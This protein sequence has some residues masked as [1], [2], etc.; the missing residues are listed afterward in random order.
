MERVITVRCGDS[1]HRLH[2]EPGQ[3]TPLDHTPGDRLYRYLGGS[4][5]GCYHW[6]VDLSQAD[7][8]YFGWWRSRRVNYLRRDEDAWRRFRDC[9]EATRGII[10]AFKK[11]PLH[12]SLWP[13]W[14]WDPVAPSL[15]LALGV[16]GTR[17]TVA[18]PVYQFQGATGRWVVA[19]TAATAAAISH[20]DLSIVIVKSSQQG[21]VTSKRIFFCLPCRWHSGKRNK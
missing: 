20:R 2:L 17:S 8:L 18:F 6:A 9:V 15:G 21:K 4:M 12:L 1:R 16:P 13:L 11:R 19:E 5:C 14:V 3:I 7:A 10:D